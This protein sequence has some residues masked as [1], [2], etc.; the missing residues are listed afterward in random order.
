MPVELELQ[1]QASAGNSLAQ[2][3]LSELIGTDLSPL[4]FS[5]AHA[6]DFCKRHT[7][8]LPELN[9]MATPC[10]NFQQWKN[11]LPFIASEGVL[12]ESS[13]MRVSMSRKLYTYISEIVLTIQGQVGAAPLGEVQIEVADA[14]RV[15][16]VEPIKKSS[17]ASEQGVKT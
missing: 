7:V 1:K 5:Q 8:F 10:D 14:D 17:E 3:A 4:K 9:P 2:G 13:T 6:G 11:L 16:I 15:T 12:H